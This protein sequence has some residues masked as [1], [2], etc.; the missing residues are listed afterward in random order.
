MLVKMYSDQQLYLYSVPYIS[1]L[2]L[3]KLRRSCNVVIATHEDQGQ[4]V[5]RLMPCDSHQKYST[6]I[7]S[8]SLSQTFFN[9][10]R[11]LIGQDRQL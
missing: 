9:A 8:Q 7:L 6:N 1:V 5:M 4:V 10:P 3:K 11:P 2:L